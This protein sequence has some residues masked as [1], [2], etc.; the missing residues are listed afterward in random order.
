M[1]HFAFQN[2]LSQ[3]PDLKLF[4]SRSIPP[5]VPKRPSQDER[6]SQFPVIRCNHFNQSPLADPVRFEDVFNANSNQ[7]A[8]LQ[9]MIVKRSVLAGFRDMYDRFFFPLLLMNLSCTEEASISRRNCYE[10][11]RKIV[12]EII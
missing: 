9:N 12:V 4:S 11:I 10:V 2:M 1:L 6:E 8:A 3:I 7:V 5:P